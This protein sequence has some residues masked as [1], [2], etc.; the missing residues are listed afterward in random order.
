MAATAAGPSALSAPGAGEAV[1]RFD[2]DHGV[3]D[4]RVHMRIEKPGHVGV[5]F[6]RPD[7]KGSQ[8]ASLEMQVELRPSCDEGGFVENRS[9][10]T[11]SGHFPGYR[12]RFWRYL[13]DWG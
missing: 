5:Y 1:D 13:A 2:Y 9:W 11:A 3:P 6:G 8:R 12:E 4:K 7:A 10:V